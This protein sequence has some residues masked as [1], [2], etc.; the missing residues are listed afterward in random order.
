[1]KWW[2]PV[3]ALTSAALAALAAGVQYGLV[4][5]GV[6]VG[7]NALAMAM[8]WFRAPP[9]LP[10]V[11]RGLCWAAALQLPVMLFTLLDR[12]GRFAAAPP[13][14]SD[15]PPHGDLDDPLAGDE[16]G[17]GSDGRGH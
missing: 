13:P 7:A 8:A 4:V 6:Y 16:R 15:A 3:W 12:D 14:A 9:V 10:A 2:L 5:I 11:L 17:H 1:V